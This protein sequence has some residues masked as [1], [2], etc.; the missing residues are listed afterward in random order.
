MPIILIFQSHDHVADPEYSYWYKDRESNEW[1]E[2]GVATLWKNNT[3]YFK[4]T[5]RTP[6]F[7]Q[8]RTVDLWRVI[9]ERYR[10][11]KYI[12]G[13]ELLNEPAMAGGTSMVDLRNLY[14]RITE[15]IRSVD[16]NHM[17]VVEGLHWGEDIDDLLPTWDD[18]MA[19]AFHRYWKQAGYDDGRIEGY[20]AARDEHNV[21]F[22]LTE[23]GENSN[24]WMYEMVQLMN[25]HDIGWFDWGFKKVDTIC[26]A[27]NINLTEDYEYVIDNWRDNH[28]I[29][30]TRAKK[31]LMELA[32]SPGILRVEV[33][34]RI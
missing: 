23:F 31:G 25:D 10:D 22:V 4:R 5:G 32:E 13:Y 9:A 8:Q 27:Y 16:Q 26:A 2:K 7:N 17:I 30:S 18:N 1:S 33:I 28:N 3:Q 29:D 21:P 24:S 20:L 34:P 19:V 11:E 12:Y 15:A 6:E 14:V